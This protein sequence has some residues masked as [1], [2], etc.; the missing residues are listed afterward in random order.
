VPGSSQDAPPPARARP[1]DSD[2]SLQ[3]EREIPRVS[4]LLS[5]NGQ[6]NPVVAD[7]DREGTW[8]RVRE[9]A[10]WFVARGGPATTAT[11]KARTTLSCF[12]EPGEGMSDADLP[13]M[14]SASL[15]RLPQGDRVAIGIERGHAHSER[16]RL[17]LRLDE[18]DS[19]RFELG[20]ISS[21]II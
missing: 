2:V 20:I 15:S 4:Q 14:R 3:P 7:L 18:F 1:D 8:I 11:G 13:A 5:R 6:A 17:R 21:K 16:I 10:N 9:P 12:F 19:T